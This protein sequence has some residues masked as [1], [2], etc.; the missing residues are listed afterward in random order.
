MFSLPGGLDPQAVARAI[1]A[2]IG[3]PQDRQRGFGAVVIHPGRATA[4]E[5]T[6]TTPTVGGGD[7]D[8]RQAV[9]LVLSLAQG[10][11][12]LPST[13]QIRA[14]QQRVE[15]AGPVEAIKFLEKQRDERPARI[16]GAWEAIHQPLVQLIKD[17]QARPAIVVH[18]LEVLSDLTLMAQ[19]EERR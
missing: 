17:H 14:V 10:Q 19:R 2:G 7:A 9:T 12:R 5:K 18:A 1:R 4:M 15:R 16:W 11:S 6:G 3:D 13:S 8:R